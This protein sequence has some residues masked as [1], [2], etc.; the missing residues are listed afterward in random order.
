MR[1]L[2]LIYDADGSSANGITEGAGTGWNT[3][4]TNKPWYDGSGYV[5]WP[6]TNTDIATFGGGTSG[7]AGTVTV[8]SVITNKI[9]FE[10]TF[11]G[12]YTLNG[13]TI[14]MDGTTPT[15]TVNNVVTNSVSTIN[16]VLAGTAGLIKNG[17][18]SLTLA[19][20]SSNTFSGT[21]SVSAGTLT[22][23]KSTAG[24]NAVGGDILVNG[25][26]LIWGRAN[27]VPDSASITLV[28]GGLQIA[29]QA[30]TITN[31]TI[32]GGNANFNTSSNG[33]TFTISDTLAI[34]GS[35]A[36][37]GLN[38]GANWSANKVDFTG[39]VGTVLQITG[40]SGT[41]TSK[42]T[43]GAGGLILT[44]Q[45]LNINKGTTG[46][47][48]ELVL[49]GGVTASGTNN[50]NF[51]STSGVSR[52]TMAAT[53]TWN[54]TAGT[55]TINNQVF[56]AGGL[57]KTGDGTLAF[58]GADA[59]LYSGTTTISGGTLAMGKTA[60]VNAIAGSVT[61]STGAV[62]DWNGND[63]LDD[64]VNLTLSGGS[65]KLDNANETFASLTQTS[66]TV[67]FGGS[68]NAGIVNITGLLRV[69]GGSSINMNSGGVWSA[70]TADFTGFN[71][72]NAVSMNGN[73]TG[74]MNQFIVGSGGLTLTGGNVSLSFGADPGT[75]GSELTL[76]GNVTASS[77]SSIVVAA[78][79]GIGVAQVNLGTSDR[80]WNIVNGT[81][82]S[83][84]RVIGAGGG[85]VKTGNG[86]LAFNGVNTYT[87][88]TTIS[89][90]TFKLGTGASIDNSPRI[91]VASGASFDVSAVSGY[92]VK[93]GQTLEGG[94]TITGSATI[95]S[96]AT[97]RA[98]TQ[99]GDTTQKLTVTAGL[100]LNS[101]ST[102]QIEIN[103]ATYTS[104][105]GFGGNLPGTAG[106]DA[107][108]LSHAS[109]LGDH[110][111][112]GVGT[113]FSQ[114]TGAQVKVL[115]AIFSPIW[116]QIFNLIDW[117]SVGTMSTNLGSNYRDGSSDQGTDLDLPDISGSGLTWDISHYATQ[118]I[119]VVVPEPSRVLLLILGGML[120]GLR[121]RRYVIG[122]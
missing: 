91:T 92:S 111:Q 75:Q 58:A 69:S 24:L 99:G 107:Y 5:A 108:V 84:A 11:A 77:N 67:N 83:A 45:T 71:S 19:G 88:N 52:V 101:G 54:V 6:N 48:S 56:G 8:G 44:G 73:S 95:L 122:S 20:G 16:S 10:T 55:T 22:M 25:G 57:T 34:N 62:L 104:T 110:G 1:A 116:G 29:G 23:N 28:S 59:N 7:T 46:M 14:T 85:V 18:G 9:I 70:G 112:I 33:G 109:G 63:Q 26:V 114:Q 74:R 87:G 80:T 37:L 97:L 93:S 61:V 81:T 35:G 102:T 86:I 53:Q 119:V 79:N 82:T 12:N 21:T 105:D 117:A 90:G 51:A 2:A 78:A 65:L 39:G 49:N 121:R 100:T 66:G 13:G 115:P 31:L 113:A 68:T 106:Y 94:G 3:T 15:I 64:S 42:F 32:Q 120:L 72:G 60:G 89:A 96:G 40:N 36:T 103:G 41:S 4:I 76:N 38:S 30:E 98:G 17:A 47:G 27:M 50:I 118:G 43:V